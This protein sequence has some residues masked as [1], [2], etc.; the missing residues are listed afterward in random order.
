MK[1]N[2]AFSNLIRI[3]SYVRIL[4]EL[5]KTQTHKKTCPIFNK[6]T[7]KQVKPMKLEFCGGSLSQKTIQSSTPTFLGHGNN[8]CRKKMH[9]RCACCHCHS[10]A[11]QARKA[12]CVRNFTFFPKTMRPFLFLM[13]GSMIQYQYFLVGKRKQYIG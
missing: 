13:K 9:L 1:T 10:A 6:Q 3:Y 11:T 7:P 12:H 4:D 5:E 8:F 2:A